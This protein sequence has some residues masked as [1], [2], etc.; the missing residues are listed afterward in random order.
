M[1]SQGQRRV[2]G[3]R[4]STLVLC[5][6][7][8]VPCLKEEGRTPQHICPAFHDQEGNGCLGVISPHD[9]MSAHAGASKRGFCL[10]A[11]CDFFQIAVPHRQSQDLP[12]E[13]A[14][15]EQVIC[16][17]SEILPQST[18]KQ[19][20]PSQGVPMC[21][22]AFYQDALAGGGGVYCQGHAKWH[23]C[24]PGLQVTR[25]S[26]SWLSFILQKAHNTTCLLLFSFLVLLYFPRSEP[27][28]VKSD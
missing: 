25:I 21:I 12:P 1:V 24:V 20:L 15:W 13:A 10:L 4:M 23:S 18:P 7:S 11:G 26:C 17:D 5:F 28:T 14:V 2:L 22:G 19:E 3:L 16:K 27:L 9:P 6:T 8:Q